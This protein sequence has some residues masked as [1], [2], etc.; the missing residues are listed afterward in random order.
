MSNLSK[1]DMIKL[2]SSNACSSSTAETSL[3]DNLGNESLIK[4]N[5]KQENLQT[6]N[7]SNNNEKYKSEIEKESKVEVEKQ[8]QISVKRKSIIPLFKSIYNES[9]VFS[10]DSSK[11]Q[12][13]N[14]PT[15]YYNKIK[16]LYIKNYF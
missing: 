7:N 13:I 14:K 11:I 16:V 2:Q 5:T 4:N 6:E 8:E 12:I 10:V 15:D 1:Q 3:Q 9:A